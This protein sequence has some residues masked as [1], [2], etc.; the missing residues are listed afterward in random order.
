MERVLRVFLDSM[1]DG[2]F[3]RFQNALSRTMY[4]ELASGYRGDEDEVALVSRLVDCT[5]GKSYGPLK[6]DAAKIHGT[7]SYVDFDHLDEHVTKELGDM[8]L[9]S[10]VTDGATR[11]VQKVCIIQNK[12]G[13]ES[14]PKKG[15]NTRWDID[16]EQLFLLKNF[17]P[18]SGGRGILRNWREVAFRN[19]TGALGAYALLAS[20]G[21][22]TF[23]LAPIVA[24]LLGGRKSLARADMSLL[25]SNDVSQSSCPFFGIDSWLPHRMILGHRYVHLMIKPSHRYDLPS[26]AARA[27]GFP[28]LGRCRYCRDIFEFARNWTQFN[29]GEPC[30]IS[31][32]I[33]DRPLDDFSGFLLRSAG[34]GGDVAFGGGEQVTAMPFPGH[35]AVFLLTMDVSGG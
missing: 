10:A 20:P 27:S 17:P 12:K 34:L 5:K 8:V 26:P 35:M 6:I 15:P 18:L 9:I 1:G 7:R 24:D 25:Q 13:R 29:I 3:L 32:A 31:G 2:D 19:A 21:E 16:L 33:V 23:A 14:A 30:V 4:H 28:F 22:M 11:L